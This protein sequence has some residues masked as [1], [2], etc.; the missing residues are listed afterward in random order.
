MTGI[1]QF[2]DPGQEPELPPDLQDAVDRLGKPPGAAPAPPMSDRD[3]ANMVAAENVDL[4]ARIIQLTQMCIE[5]NQAIQG[6][7]RQV[8]ANHQTLHKLEGRIRQLEARA[9]TSRMTKIPVPAEPPQGLKNPH[10]VAVPLS[11]GSPQNSPTPFID[12][13][14]PQLTPQQRQ[15]ADVWESAGKE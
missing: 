15:T 4:T 14:T 3:V 8:D 6:M 7:I 12:P 2:I 11:A 9:S 13:G 10:I 1:P 5:M